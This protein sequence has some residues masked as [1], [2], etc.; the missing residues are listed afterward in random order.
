MKDRAPLGL[1]ATRIGDENWR[2]AARAKKCEAFE[3]GY[4]VLNKYIER[5]RENRIEEALLKTMNQHRQRPN[6]ALEKW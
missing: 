4:I 3:L 6:R 2:T 5:E 1:S